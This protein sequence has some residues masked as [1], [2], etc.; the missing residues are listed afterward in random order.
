MFTARCNSEA[1]APSKRRDT[2]GMHNDTTGPP[3]RS[4]VQNIGASGFVIPTKSQMSH[5]CLHV[6]SFNHWHLQIVRE[7]SQTSACCR[8][9]VGSQSPTRREVRRTRHRVNY[10]GS[11]LACRRVSILGKHIP[12]VL[13]PTLSSALPSLNTQTLHFLRNATRVHIIWRPHLSSMHFQQRVTHATRMTGR[14][15]HYVC[16][17]PIAPAYGQTSVPTTHPF[18]QHPLAFTASERAFLI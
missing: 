18:Q 1:S 4:F 9:T 6:V 16:Y 15:T 8:Y 2:Q 5:F 12:E 13:L 14:H 17:P 10:L 3:A 11:T 7:T